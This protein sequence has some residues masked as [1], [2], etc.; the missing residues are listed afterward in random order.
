[1]LNIETERRTE[2]QGNEKTNIHLKP[3]E[4]YTS[5]ENLLEINLSLDY[6]DSHHESITHLVS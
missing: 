2:N 1:M 6:E 5:E 4:K 3:L